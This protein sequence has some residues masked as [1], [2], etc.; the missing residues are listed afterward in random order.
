M[1]WVGVFGSFSRAKQRKRSDV[2]LVIFYDPTYS[3]EQIWGWY[4]SSEENDD[5]WGADPDEP[6]LEK[7]WNRKVDILRIFAGTLCYEKDVEAI[8]LAQTVYG[9]FN[10]PTLQ[11]L[12]SLFFQK[13]QEYQKRINES[14]M[15][16]SIARQLDDSSE[17][18][19]YACQKIAETLD[20]DRD[21]PLYL[22]VQTP[23]NLAEDLAKKGGSNLT[24]KEPIEDLWSMLYNHKVWVR[25][26]VNNARFAEDTRAAWKRSPGVSA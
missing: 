4:S 23:R 15:L 17:G 22:L 3:D 1:V 24:W 2:D 16:A 12:H 26:I 9:N 14:E 5:G 11:S 18:Y 19:Q 8:L 10:N 7:A 13:A 6:K 25:K 20:A 21:D